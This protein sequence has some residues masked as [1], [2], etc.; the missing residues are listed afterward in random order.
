MG[1]NGSMICCIVLLLL[2]FSP[3]TLSKSVTE[4]VDLVIQGATS[5]AKTDD[6]FI[7]V[8]LD[9]WPPNKCDYGQCPWG[10]SGIFNFAFNPLRIR[11][12]GSLQDQ[13]IY[14]VGGV[15][16]CPHLKKSKEKE[17][18][19]GFSKGCLEMKRWDE[20]NAFF[21]QTGAKIT[22]SLNA[23]IGRKESK[24]EKS[25]WVGNWYPHNAKD[26]MK[27]T[28][29]KGYK[30]DSYELG[31]ELCGSGV[32]ARIEAKQYGKDMIVLKKLI[33]KLYPNQSTQP[34]V[35]GPGG[36][37]EEEWFNTFL[38]TTGPDVLHGVTHHIYNLGPGNDPNLINTIQD[39]YHLNQIAQ[40]FKDVSNA[41]D[42]FTPWAGAWVGESGGAY[43]SG[44][45][46]VSRTFAD[47]FWY[48][49]QLGM[50]S[51]YNH[52]VYCRQALIGGNYAMLNTTTFIPNP[53]Y[54][55][56]LLWNQNM[57]NKVLAATH[58]GSPYLRAYSHCAREKPGVSVILINLSNNTSFE[59]SL[60]NDETLH[61][62]R[63]NFEIKGEQAREEYHLT[64]KDGNIQ[65]DVVLLNGT[66]LKLTD[67]LEIPKMNPKL[68]DAS[69]PILVEAH[70][71]VYLTI[72][73]FNAPACA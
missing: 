55:G 53:D 48:L 46:D 38:K 20:L 28:I 3:S 14:K 62:V 34:K 47:G 33:K 65:S 66:P 27:Y 21:N 61:G 35:I 31:N 69:S 32:S 24:T 40:T 72:R 63:P 19:F 8:T 52:K 10:K 49:D 6:N 23:L 64:P 29:S 43:N 45:K 26:L 17:F 9:Y 50:T 73:D 25:L 18:L 54:Y 42:K 16:K 7:C 71:I 51:V 70:S 44:G 15:K 22:F 4:S 41:V 58:E 36:F 57:G 13:V 60:S 68:V 67:S 59:V 2:W 11:V 5:I 56:A 1:V 37:Y 30:I 39:P 12:G